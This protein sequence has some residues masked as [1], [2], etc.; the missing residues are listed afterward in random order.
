MKDL[1]L[2]ESPELRANVDHTAVGDQI[3]GYFPEALV[4]ILSHSVWFTL[5][6]SSQ[7]PNAHS[8]LAENRWNRTS[9]MPLL[10]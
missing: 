5:G 3:Q 9:R 2:C 4:P 8:T 6:L 1:W 10:T 7:S